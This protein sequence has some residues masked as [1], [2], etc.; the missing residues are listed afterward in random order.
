MYDPDEGT[1][2]QVEQTKT[3][4]RDKAK[5]LF[6]HF[7]YS[8]TSIGDIAK[9]CAMSPGNLYR[10][11]RNKQAIGQAVVESYFLVQGQ[12]MID[13]RNSPGRSVEARLRMTITAGVTHLVEMMGDNPRLFEMAEFL[14]E[15]PG[16]AE[17]MDRHRDWMS[18]VLSDLV[19]E[20]VGS[21]ELDVPNAPE[22]GWDLL[23]TTTAFW[24]PQA[25]VAWHDQTKIL[26]DL[27]R[28]L[29]RVLPGMRARG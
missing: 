16:G 3:L 10:Y 18:E 22:A 9:A 13:A 6:G 11:F 19:L 2:P 25:L 7:G 1:S 24:M 8:K 14:C 23:L 21:G 5:A 26:E 12:R 20:G 28:V 4:I 29:D 15:D 17:L 27:Q